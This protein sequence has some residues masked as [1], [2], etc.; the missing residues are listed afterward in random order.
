MAINTINLTNKDDIKSIYEIANNILNDSSDIDN[1]NLLEEKYAGDVSSLLY[2]VAIK[3]AKSKILIKNIDKKISITIVFAVYNE[4]NRIQ[5]SNSHPNGEN[6]IENKIEQLNWLFE[7]RSDLIDWKM[8]IMD[9]G[10]PNN[11]GLIAKNIIE[12]KFKKYNI[13]VLFLENAIKE[14]LEITSNLTSTNDSQK[15]GSIIYGLWQASN[16]NSNSNH[17]IIYTDADLSIH[18]SQIGLLINDIINSDAKVSIGTKRDRKSV[19]L[20]SNNRNLRGMFFISLWKQLI[21]DLKY[22]NDTQCPLKAFRADLIHEIIEDNIESKFA[23]DIE[24]LLKSQLNQANKNAPMIKS[25]PIAVIDSEAESTTIHLNPYLT[26]LK[27]IAKMYKRY[28]PFNEKSEKL[29]NFLNLLDENDWT[30]LV[31][32]IPKENIGRKVN[33][34]K[35]DFLV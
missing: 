30:K 13:E 35:Y 28:L 2:N 4:H 15:G 29:A 21:P 32:N 25:Q 10:C 6:F 34:F 17:I 18:L 26:M 19:L 14:N 31:D 9:D 8:I 22:L 20:K 33:N 24:L 12:T 11:S 7:D 23:F 16:E 5:D 27:T 1:I 3:I